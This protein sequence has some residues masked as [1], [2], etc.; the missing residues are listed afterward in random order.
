M[1]EPLWL[2]LSSDYVEQ[3]LAAEFGR[4]PP[5]FL[6]VGMKRLFEY[7]IERIG[8]GKE[9]WI[10]L[11]ESFEPPAADL[12]I[13]RHAGVQILPVPDGF[14]LGEAVV[15]VCNLI[16]AG[17]RALN[18]L[19]GDT[20]IDVPF[21]GEQDEVA[22]AETADGYSWAEVESGADGFVA[23]L[24]TVMAGVPTD[25]QHPVACGYFA[26][27]TASEIVRCL[28]R[29]RCDFVEGVT[30]YA[31]ARRMRARRVDSWFDFG[32]LRTFYQ[33]RRFVTTERAFNSLRIV[34]GTVRKV[35]SALPD[36]IVAEATWYAQLPPPLRIYAARLI[37]AGRTADGDP[38]YETEYEYLPTLAELFVFGSLGRV[39][40]NG[41]IQSCADFLTACA[42]RPVGVQNGTD[43]LVTLIRPKTLD[44][45][46]QFALDSDISIDGEMRYRGRPL[47][48][49]VRI[50]EEVSALL[51]G[52][53]PC[54]APVM[55]GD[56]CFS[57]ILYN[58]RVRRVRVIDPRGY[59]GRNETRIDGD[60]RYDLAKLHHSIGGRYDHIV[61]GRYS[62]RGNGND[63]SIDFE[64][65]PHQSWVESAFMDIEIESVRADT[66]EVKAIGVSLFLSMLP[67]HADQPARQQAF[68]ANALRLYAALA[69]GGM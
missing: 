35:S 51:D 54:P 66:E 18:L 63:Y 3:E 48:S 49:L 37:D 2:I 30:L 7:Q 56:F 59:V 42:V 16:A 65:L 47:P 24:R 13:L 45:L 36:K 60:T 64:N 34:N 26:F 69:G 4:L 61:A 27:S 10:T 29:A 21:A 17:G 57:N 32:H 8:A 52:R 55:H 6:P 44:R 20:L 15:Y 38:Y 67:L 40:W 68:V 39:S 28:V 9:V 12:E 19:H 23:S 62:L 5:C 25:R 31:K 1:R 43:A 22:V 33:S 58:S 14:S 41:I 53:R 11:P 46:E 50:A